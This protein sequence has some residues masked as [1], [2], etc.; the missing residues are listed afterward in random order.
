MLADLGLDQEKDLDRCKAMLDDVTATIGEY[1]KAI[2][3]VQQLPGLASQLAELKALTPV[4]KAAHEKIATLSFLSRQRLKNAHV[5][6]GRVNLTVARQLEQ[7]IDCAHSDLF[8]LS[9]ASE[10]AVTNLA[11]HELR[12]RPHQQVHIL[13][14]Q[15]AE[16]FDRYDQGDYDNDDNAEASRSSARIAFIRHVL[17][18]FRI[19]APKRLS[20]IISTK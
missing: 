10:Q 11:Q 18:A 13:I 9:I 2:R 12:G 5:E 3:F 19:A 16:M 8:Q 1:R 17:S 14:K 20:T 4:L 7:A 6:A 15:L